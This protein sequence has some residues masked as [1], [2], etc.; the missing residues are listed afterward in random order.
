MI[1]G[2]VFVWA[3]VLLFLCSG[4]GIWIPFVIVA[5]AVGALFL[6]KWLDFK[7]EE[8]K[9]EKAWKVIEKR[10]KL[11]RRIKPSFLTRCKDLMYAVFYDIDIWKGY[12]YY[13]DKFNKE[14]GIEEDDE[15]NDDVVI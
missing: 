12:K 11:D 5:L 4:E 7:W 1:R 13:E 15:E 8:H 2:A 6:Q 10:E 3:I 14:L 9:R